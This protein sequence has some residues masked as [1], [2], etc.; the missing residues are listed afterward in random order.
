MEN[1]NNQNLKKNLEE[2]L[3]EKNMENQLIA[4]KGLKIIENSLKTY[5]NKFEIISQKSE[6]LK[7]IIIFV[8]EINNKFPTELSIAEI[9]KNIEN[10]IN[11]LK[12]SNELELKNKEKKEIEKKAEILAETL[13]SLK[14]INNNEI[15]N[16]EIQFSSNNLKNIIK[17]E[18]ILN[19]EENNSKENFP[20]KENIK[21]DINN[22]EEEEKNKENDYNLSLKFDSTKLITKL[23]FISNFLED[24]SKNNTDF[25]QIKNSQILE[26]SQVLF[27]KKK[28]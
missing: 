9:S 16:E 22:F 19:I 21:S 15:I 12:N 14:E 1:D 28:S 17:E 26:I 2:I 18:R 27:I 4:L 8:K 25:N 3:L 20:I 11:N 5:E 7:E 13:I 10:F 24:F 23:D 6:I